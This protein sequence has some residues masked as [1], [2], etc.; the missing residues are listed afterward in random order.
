MYY[1]QEN[2]LENSPS[3]DIRQQMHK[4]REA[5]QISYDLSGDQNHI[6]Q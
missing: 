1:R 5:K 4:F 6:S 2:R 3:T